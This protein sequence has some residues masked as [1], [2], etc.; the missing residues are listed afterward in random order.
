MSTNLLDIDLKKFPE[1]DKIDLN[2]CAGYN[3]GKEVAFAEL[4]D[5]YGVPDRLLKFIHPKM[6]NPHKKQRIKELGVDSIWESVDGKYIIKEDFIKNL[7]LKKAYYNEGVSSDGEHQIEVYE[8]DENGDSIFDNSE[9][10]TVET[11]RMAEVV[12]ECFNDMKTTDNDDIYQVM[13]EYQI[14]NMGKIV[15]STLEQSMEDNVASFANEDKTQ[16]LNQN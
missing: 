14:E 7:P 16:T 4:N 11:A 12:A 13:E 9:F 8:V 6:L 2:K 10:F 15:E 1:V 3:Q 5:Y